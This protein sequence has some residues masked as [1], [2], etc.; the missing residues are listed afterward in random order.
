MAAV[1]F[2]A[3]PNKRTAGNTSETAARIRHIFFILFFFSIHFC[4]FFYFFFLF[5]FTWIT[6]ERTVNIYMSSV[7]L[8]FFVEIIFFF[9]SY[10]TLKLPLLNPFLNWSSLEILPVNFKTPFT[11]TKN[12][13]VESSSHIMALHFLYI[14][15]QFFLLIHRFLHLQKQIPRNFKRTERDSSGQQKFF[16]SS[17]LFLPMLIHHFD[18]VYT[19]IYIYIYSCESE[20]MNL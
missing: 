12:R 19:C 20:G 9:F 6:Y 1:K 14:F 2:I 10:Q 16:S 8:P 18:N 17:F 7:F 4:L 5:L 13:A 15:L 11:V 3:A